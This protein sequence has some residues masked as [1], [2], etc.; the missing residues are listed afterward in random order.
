MSV[1]CAGLRRLSVRKVMIAPSVVQALLSVKS[2]RSVRCAV[3][4][5][6]VRR[7]IHPPGAA[8]RQPHAIAMRKSQPPAWPVRLAL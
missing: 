4:L 5:H 1:L 3:H 7:M 6:G 2:V 8:L